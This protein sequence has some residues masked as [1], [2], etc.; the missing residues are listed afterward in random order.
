VF[1]GEYALLKKQVRR[2]KKTEG[3]RAERHVP[4]V[5]FFRS[6]AE[7]QKNRAIGV[8]A[9]LHLLSQ[10]AEV[11]RNG[12]AKTHYAGIVLCSQAF[13]LYEVSFIG[14]CWWFPSSIWTGGQ[15][16]KFHKNRQPPAC[17]RRVLKDA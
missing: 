5:L 13:R 9:G 17:A 15:K 16:Y 6:L 2:L 11:S 3:A 1:S 12:F 10:R 14:N 8:M 4:T 7:D